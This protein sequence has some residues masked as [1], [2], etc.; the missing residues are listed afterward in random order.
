MELISSFVTAVSAGVAGFFGHLLAHD[1]AAFAPSLSRHLIKKAAGGL[2]KDD[3]ARYAEEWLA[4]LNERVGVL[5]KLKHV[6]GC[7]ICARRMRRQSI[8]HRQTAVVFRLEIAGGEIIE[9]D[10]STG[11]W[12]AS[13]VRWHS[14]MRGWGL[15]NRV[16]SQIGYVVTSIRLRKYGAPDPTKALRVTYAL[17]QLGGV[18]G[19]KLWAGKELLLDRPRQGPPR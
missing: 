19:Y 3:R 12:F 15:N 10:G 13:A 6:C 9:F 16:F 14:M 8:W 2:S 17:V 18:G 11:I 4:D 5:S 7:M 1:F